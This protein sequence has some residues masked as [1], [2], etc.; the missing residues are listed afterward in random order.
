MFY[1]SSDQETKRW[2]LQ[3]FLGALGIITLFLIYFGIPVLALQA[4]PHGL[5][6]FLHM[7]GTGEARTG[8]C[9]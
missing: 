9:A 4:Q 1:G 8:I 3:H 5:D 7:I 6:H 2:L